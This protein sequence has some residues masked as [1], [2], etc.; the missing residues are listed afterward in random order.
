MSS[1]LI[2]LSY[3]IIVKLR[4]LELSSTLQVL[5]PLRFHL[6]NVYMWVPNSR[7]EI[8]S[9]VLRWRQH[10]YVLC[11][12]VANIF[13]QILIS[14]GDRRY[15][16]ILWRESTVDPIQVYKL[17]TV[18]Y[19]MACSPYL[20]IR[21]LRQLAK[22]EES[23]FPDAASVLES[24]SYVDDIFLGGQDMT[25]TLL[26]R[27][28]MIQFTGS[29][30]FQLR[31]WFS[32]NPDLLAGLPDIEHGLA[33]EIPLDDS[34]GFKVLGIFWDPAADVIRYR[35]STLLSEKPSKRSIVS[36]VAK[37][38]DPLWW[39]TPVTIL[40]KILL[41]KLWLRKLDWDD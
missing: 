27:D 24:E 34:S 5:S 30:G 20:A 13:S 23:N 41:Q 29:G 7:N 4:N 25:S 1:F 18:T 36:T 11:A 37:H 39:I 33:V 10:K 15:Q 17:S 19:G 3:E 14:P 31:K 9:I 21:V 12:D 28:Q 6:T 38:F 2:I 26:L 35:F 22:D 16:C 32:N 40:T 8:S